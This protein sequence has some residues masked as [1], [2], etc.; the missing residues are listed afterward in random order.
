MLTRLCVVAVLLLFPSPVRAEDHARDR[1]SVALL[2]AGTV[3]VGLSAWDAGLTYRAVKSHQANEANPLIVP[4]V[5]A[6]GIGSA[7]VGKL[8]IDAGVIG[9][10]AY[11]A[12]R[13]PGSKRAML[14]GHIAQA[15]VKMF[16]ISHNMRVLRGQ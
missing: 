1:L 14:G 9:G 13:W 11:I 8:A 10:M 12:K 3:N 7:M 4:F 15:A 5:E 2:A 6:H 16:V